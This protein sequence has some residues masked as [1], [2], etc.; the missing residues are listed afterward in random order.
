MRIA[1]VQFVRMNWLKLSV[2]DPAIPQG[3][4][5]EGWV[6]QSFGA[7][8]KDNQSAKLDD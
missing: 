3:L 6:D 1:A 2:L 5:L 8:L 7:C 4:L